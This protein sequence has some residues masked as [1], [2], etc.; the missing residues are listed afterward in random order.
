MRLRGDLKTVFRRSRGQAMGR[1]IE[2]LNLKLR[3]WMNY[4]RHIGVTGILQELDGWV[5]RN[6]RKILWLQ[7][8]R[9]LY[10]RIRSNHTV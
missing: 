4:F 6:L 3:G 5:R 2:A 9:P 10:G 8:K 1:V 7:W